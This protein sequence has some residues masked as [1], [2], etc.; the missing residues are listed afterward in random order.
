MEAFID[1]VGSARLQEQLWA[2]ILGRGAFPRFKDVLEQHLAERE[3]WVAFRDA[4]VRE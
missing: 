4:C 3:R 1:T 2:A